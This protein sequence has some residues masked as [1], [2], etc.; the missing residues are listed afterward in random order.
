MRTPFD[1]EGIDYNEIYEIVLEAS[2]KTFRDVQTDHPDETFYIFGFHEDYPT[3]LSCF[4]HPT[5]QSEQ[6][7]MRSR[8]LTDADRE[9]QDLKWFYRRWHPR[10][11]EYYRSGEKYFKSAWSWVYE[12][13]RKDTHPPEE[14]EL[15]R[16]NIALKMSAMYFKVLK[17]LDEEKLFG[18]GSAREGVLLNLIA[19]ELSE[20]AHEFYHHR[21]R[22]VLE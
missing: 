9:A 6:A 10:C 22:S 11:W 4:M 17:T 5:C 21:R 3:A 13:L 15:V 16:A 8:N 2:R 14:A 18:Q 7:H 1:F 12:N 19:R 20:R